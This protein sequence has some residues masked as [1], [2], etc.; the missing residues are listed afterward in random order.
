MTTRLTVLILW[1]VLCGMGSGSQDHAAAS[2]RSQ[3]DVA[4]AFQRD[5]SWPKPLPNGWVLGTVSAV[6]TDS[7][8]HVWILHRPSTLTAENLKQ[9]KKQPAPPVVEVDADGNFVQAWGGP[10]AGYSW[11]A[12]VKVTEEPYPTA[13]NGEH[14]IFVDDQYVWVC[15]SGHVVLKFTRTGK[16]VLQLGQFRKTAGS[17]DPRLLGKPTDVVVDHA[18]DEVFVADG[19]VNRR[20][21]VFDANTG[22]YKR[23][24]G[25][26]GMKPDDGPPVNYEQGEPLPRQFFIVHCLRIANDGLVYVCDRQRNRIQVFKKDGTFVREVVVDGGAAAGGGITV[27]G[28]TAVAARGGFG[29]VNCVALSADAEQQY[30]YVAG[31]R[32]RIVILRRRDLKELGSFESAGN[33]QM[34][35]DRKGNIYVSGRGMPERFL[36]KGLP[37]SL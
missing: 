9:A 8:N 5:A 2:S 35:T 30:L 17:N 11:M 27:P 18:T 16:F 28:P 7:R 4:P 34:A 15:G 22:A 14:G 13:E 32:S 19:Y 20:V 3:T 23:H 10:G 31:A 25:G 37:G 21:V 29:S 1:A 12:P 24:W 36:F 33:H 26:Y 6:A